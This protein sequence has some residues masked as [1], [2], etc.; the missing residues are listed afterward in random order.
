MRPLT[1]QPREQPGHHPRWCE[2]ISSA[3]R[4]VPAQLRP[5]PRRPVVACSAVQRRPSPGDRPARLPAP[6]ESAEDDGHHWRTSPPDGGA[7]SRRCAV[8]ESKWSLWSEGSLLSIASQGSVL[9]IGSVGSALS[10]GSVGSVGSAFSI[11]SAMAACSLMSWWSLGSVMS[12][13]G[14]GGVMG[15]R[16]SGARRPVVRAAVLG[17]CAA[18]T[19]GAALLASASGPSMSAAGTSRG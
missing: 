15:Y 2:V 11:G 12:A 5:R 19:V 6:E 16:G 10:I 18:A 7:L 3:H 14:V 13:R 8:V 1:T 17:G 9:S 4:W